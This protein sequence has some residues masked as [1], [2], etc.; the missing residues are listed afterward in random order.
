MWL[1]TELLFTVCS[2][3][4]P[5]TLVR[6]RTLYR[7]ARRVPLCNATHYVP[8]LYDSIPQPVAVKHR[9]LWQRVCKH[10][11]TPRHVFQKLR[12]KL[13]RLL[14]FEQ[15]WTIVQ[16]TG[17]LPSPR[18]VMCAMCDRGSSYHTWL[19]EHYVVQDSDVRYNIVMCIYS[20]H[21]PSVDNWAHLDFLERRYALGV[22]FHHC[23]PLQWAISYNEFY[24][25]KWLLQ[26]P[27]LTADDMRVDDDI[28][29]HECGSWAKYGFSRFRV[30]LLE[31][32]P[33]LTSTYYRVGVW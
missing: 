19:H 23:M 27:E 24:S 9:D 16:C 13:P 5:K 29:L 11:R 25:W 33:E 4:T 1:P 12:Q 32:F 22:Q 31:R 26:H 14:E 2:Y 28:I 21:S 30:E 10:P 3:A 7:V 6:M 18:H 17:R 8:R 20:N 15:V